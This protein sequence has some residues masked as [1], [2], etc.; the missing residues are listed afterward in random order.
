MEPRIFLLIGIVSFAW[1]I[2][3]YYDFAVKTGLSI[4]GWFTSKIGGNFKTFSLLVGIYFI[5]AGAIDFGWYY[6]LV[7]PLVS[8]FLGFALIKLLREHVQWIAVTGFVILILLN[9]VIQI[10]VYQ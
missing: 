3:S 8:F 10:K 6:G 4:G 2:I 1:V 9:I 5:I 7:I